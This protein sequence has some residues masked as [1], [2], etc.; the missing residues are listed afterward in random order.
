MIEKYR[1]RAESGRRVNARTLTKRL[2]GRSRFQSFARVGVLVD[3]C[4]VT[5]LHKPNDKRFPAP[6]RHSNRDKQPYRS[7]CKRQWRDAFDVG[8][9]TLINTL[10]FESPDAFSAPLRETR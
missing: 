2:A 8:N 7:F 10:Q 3:T 6:Y 5:F 9:S 1:R 4:P